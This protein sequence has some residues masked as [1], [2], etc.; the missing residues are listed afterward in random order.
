MTTKRPP[1]QALLKGREV[2]T[3]STTLEARDDGGLQFVLEGYASLT[4][5]PYDMGSYQETIKRGAFG[6]TLSE[7][8]DVQLLINHEGL[9]IAR[10]TIPWGQPGGLQLE[11]DSRG[12]HFTAQLDREDPDAATLMRKVGTGLM[13][14][15]SFGFV[16]TRQSWNSDRSQRFLEEVSL[17]RG[18]VS[19]V[20]QGASPTTFVTARA[21]AA[22]KGRTPLSIFQARARALNLKAGGR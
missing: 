17:N 5:T 15:C 7:R 19:V 9:P 20:N 8:P 21:A 13:D 14:S 3:F 11:E 4:E 12:L 22:R 1:K 2:R 18:D 6:K 10:T 16:V